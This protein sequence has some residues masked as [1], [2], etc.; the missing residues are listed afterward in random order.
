MRVKNFS[1]AALGLSVVVLMGGMALPAKSGNA[2][3]LQP[4]ANNEQIGAADTDKIY[5]DFY[6][7][8][9]E[10]ESHQREI[11]GI[12]ELKDFADNK[13][14]VVEL[15]PVGYMIYNA[16]LTMAIEA[17]AAAESPYTGLNEN[18]IYAGAMNYFIQSSSETENYYQY[19]HTVLEDEVVV[20]DETQLTELKRQ[21]NQLAANI[22]ESA[23]QVTSRIAPVVTEQT[24]ELT[25]STL[26]KNL[27]TAG[28]NTD[29]RCVWVASAVIVWYHKI[30][31][32]WTNLA[33]NGWS[34]Q[35]VDDIRGDRKT[36][37]TLSDARWALKSYVAAV[38]GIPDGY[39]AMDTI[40]PK[41]STIFE[42][43]SSNIPVMIGSTNMPNPNGGDT[44]S[45]AV[46]VHKVARKAR[47]NWIGTSYSDYRYWA[48][49]GWGTAYNN[50]M[51]TD[52][53]FTIDSRC[54]FQN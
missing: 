9:P 38:G 48:H 26:I 50:V 6:A 54:N 52:S 35:L 2:E 47:K 3:E 23:K 12:K 49:F 53:S 32:N 19:E 16:D 27:S 1:L 34:S 25:N 5:S 41:S 20:L 31:W 4:T 8:F 18:L 11:R 13:Y 10:E 42:R 44:M 30:S 37:A 14:F 46:V 39:A 33:P 7:A 40:Y 21:S 24:A 36:A 17:N 15:S 29:G 51:L 45:H 22:E 28:F 43:V